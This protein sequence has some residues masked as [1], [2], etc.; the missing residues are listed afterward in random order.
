MS[1]SIWRELMGG[2]LPSNDRTIGR[3]RAPTR[4]R[5]PSPAAME[6]LEPRMLLS[7]GDLDPTF[8]DGG[9]VLTEFF[10]PAQP[11]DDQARGVVAVQADA[12]IPLFH[13]NHTPQFADK[14]V[15]V[16]CAATAGKL[17]HVEV[18]RN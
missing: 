9:L 8:G 7:A 4:P 17:L 16:I 10:D 11:S 2:S 6:P 5:A 12:N 3:N 1:L 15:L 14:T 18:F 13:F